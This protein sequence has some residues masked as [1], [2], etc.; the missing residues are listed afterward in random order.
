MRR[1]S[2]RLLVVGLYFPALL[3]TLSNSCF[4][5]V[6][7]VDVLE[8]ML[9]VGDPGALSVSLEELTAH[10]ASVLKLSRI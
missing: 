1:V 3:S 6:V 4:D 9:V 10:F 8:R 5:G 2:D 7:M